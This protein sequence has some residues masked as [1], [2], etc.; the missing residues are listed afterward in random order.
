M[1]QDAPRFGD[2]LRRLRMAAGLS[3]S[4]FSHRIHYSKGY[5]SK[6]ETGAA[7][8]SVS[9]AHACDRELKAGGDLASLLR[10][11]LRKAGT[12]RDGR[13][14]PIV[15]LPAM[16]PLFNGRQQ[17]LQRISAFLHGEGPRTVCALSGLSGAG[18]TALAVQASW[19]AVSTFTDGCFFLDLGRLPGVGTADPA[20]GTGEAVVYE[21]LATL[22]RLLKV[23]AE[24]IP[25]TLDAR[26]NLYRS[27]VQGVRILL[28]LD[29]VD[30]IGQIS[31][32]FP[33]EPRCRVMITS[34]NRMNALDEAVH[35][36]VGRLSVDDAVSLFRAVAGPAAEA[37]DDS[38]V[39]RVVTRCELL[40]LAIRI[41]AARFGGAR[42][43]T[44]SDF[45]A[46][47]ADETAR[48][49]V[50][51]DGERSVTAAFSLSCRG[52][53]QVQRRVF[54]L[55]ALHPSYP[56]E[57]RSIAALADLDPVGA[58]VVVD[59]LED[60]HLVAVESTGHVRVHDLV[61]EFARA[62]VLVE[63]ADDDQYAAV[64]RLLDHS[65]LLTD[66][67]DEFLAPQRYRI[68]LTPPFPPPEPFPDYQSAHSWIDREWP[69]L[70]QLCHLAA[71]RGLHRQCWQLAFLLREFFFL[72][73]LWDP[74]IDTHRRA[75]EA[76]ETAGDRMGLALT[77]NNLG[78]GHAD[79]GELPSAVEY[80]R[81]ALE[82]FRELADAHGVR[83]ATSNL[84]WATLYLGEH[85][86][87]LRGLTL[88]HRAYRGVG[89]VRNAAIA[90]R[91]MALAETELGRH[92]D[93]IRHADRA[94]EDFVQLDLTLDVAMSLN[95][96]AWAHFSS[97]DYE[98]AVTWYE[99]AAMV[100]EGCGS[101]YEAARAV[102]GIGNVHA[103]CERHSE[104]ARHWGRA[105]ELY[106]SL[107]PRMVG[108]ARYRNSNP[109]SGSLEGD[110]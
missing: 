31:V 25:P 89:N 55:L 101:R 49:A 24:R 83:N 108:E 106:R 48:L 81:Q 38:E 84:A 36:P 107:D 15:G 50:L 35:L 20:D 87:A 104:A 59:R 2:E 1:E 12:R 71:D 64:R 6:V 103:V 51:D 70:V 10:A 57:L 19:D 8:G 27:T 5:L 13:G 58:R 93:A 28:V 78:I 39:R 66:A 21:A 7:S 9:F 67:T 63:M 33:P 37:A 97:G 41:A 11:G 34:R 98:T 82:L 61:R 29:N 74:W 62:H 90:L 17:E 80:F 18:K 76:A 47:L 69:T 110:E 3:L 68:S 53:T 22:L 96:A 44:L 23:S 102:T 14:G 75:V 100:A 26:L 94:Y 54:G 32:L 95:C 43:W 45:D 42:V 85:Q 79:R 99:R 52:L 92:S 73:K 4:Q 16:T 60:A 109:L 72:A 30:N 105:D 86:E 91:G 65:L 88:V 77:L 56:M 40:P 46:R